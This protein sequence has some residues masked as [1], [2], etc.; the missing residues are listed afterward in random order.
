MLKHSELILKIVCL[1]MA[2]LFLYQFVNVVIRIR[3]LKGLKIPDLPRLPAVVDAPGAGKT[4]NNVTSPLAANKGTNSGVT[5]ISGNVETNMVASQL[6]AKTSTNS[7]P[8]KDSEK[9]PTNAFPEQAAGKKETNSA[10]LQ[11]AGKPDARVVSRTP[12]V[13]NKAPDL[14]PLIQ[15]RVDRVTQSE[16]LGPVMRPLPM[17]LVGIAGKVAF[18]RAAN[19]QT[20]L[21]KEGDELGGIKLLQI[22]TNRVLV[23]HEGQKKELT[24]FAGFGSESLLPKPKETT[25]DTAKPK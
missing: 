2:T 4:T 18:L 13:I 8:G 3:P 22:G 5:P 25:N 16:M 17:G 21:V 12:P 20:G 9:P 11:A 7:I 19:G 14:P 15:A 1:L 6:A 10:A 23:E 24:L